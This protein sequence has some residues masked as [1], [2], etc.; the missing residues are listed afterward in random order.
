MS[1]EDT[2]PSVFLVLQTIEVGELDADVCVVIELTL[3]YVENILERHDAFMWV[4]DND[5]Q[6]AEMSFSDRRAYYYEQLTRQE[7]L[8]KMPDVFAPESTAREMY[9]D[10]RFCFTAVD[11]KEGAEDMATEI[12]SMVLTSSGVTW[13]AKPEYADGTIITHNVDF[14]TIIEVRDY[15]QAKAGIT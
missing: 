15:L 9:D 4:A 10:N 12:D 14:D 13:R 2:G 5:P 3:G 11:V 6:L 8:E 1:E 7:D